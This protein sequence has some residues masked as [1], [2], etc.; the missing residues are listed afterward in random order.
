[1]DLAERHVMSWWA[2]IWGPR[3][4]PHAV[5]TWAHPNLLLYPTV[6]HTAQVYSVPLNSTAAL[7]P[8]CLEPCA[9][10]T[11]DDVDLR[12]LLHSRLRPPIPHLWEQYELLV[13]AAAVVVVTRPQKPCALHCALGR[14][15]RHSRCRPP[16]GPGGAV[17]V[18]A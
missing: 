4:A 1:M 7:K 12:L 11:Q 2:L 15:Q 16:L 6:L 3:H 10:L 18:L 14:T 8:S 5:F 9:F 13:A 17:V